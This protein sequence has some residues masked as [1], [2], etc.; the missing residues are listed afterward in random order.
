MFWKKFLI[1]PS[2][3]I[4]LFFMMTMQILID[5]LQIKVLGRELSPITVAYADTAPPS[6]DLNYPQ[7]NFKFA[8]SRVKGDENAVYLNI[9]SSQIG[10]KFVLPKEPSAT[11]LAKFDPSTN[12]GSLA[13]MRMRMVGP[14]L[15]AQILRITPTNFQS[16]LSPHF[17]NFAFLDWN[18]GSCDYA[19]KQLISTDPPHIDHAPIM[20]AFADYDYG[21][22]S[23]APFFALGSEQARVNKSNY[24]WDQRLNTDPCWTP[25]GLKDFDQNDGDWH[26]ISYNGFLNLVAFAQTVHKAALGF[27][28]ISSI[29]QDIQTTT[30]K[31]FFKKKVTE[32]VNYWLK[33]NWIVSTPARAGTYS[34]YAFNPSHGDNGTFSFVRVINNHSFPVQ[35]QL[36]YSWSKSWSGWTGLFVLVAIMVLAIVA[37]AVAGAALG[38]LGALGSSID[39][40]GGALIGAGVG[41]AV[42]GVGGLTAS[43]FSPSTA[44]TANFTPF[45]DSSYQLDPSQTAAGDALMVAN[46]TRSQWITPD[47]AATGGGV[48]TF[49]ENINIQN[50]LACGGASRTDSCSGVLTEIGPNDSRWSEAYKEMFF[51][52]HKELERYNYPYTNQ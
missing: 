46:N 15:T 41:G 8:L 42:G 11:I 32:T 21:R 17:Y 18:G 22:S 4:A 29:R 5:R 52:P 38:A 40:L 3:I 47:I 44:V 34:D 13:I 49:V 26:N 9:P 31:S 50:A 1:I 27:T 12:T 19:S 39:S 25:R 33:P 16:Y 37:C 51:F 45:S 28:A 6:T 23:I 48:Q 14:N 35:E 20:K 2:A 36:I 10:D 24:Y 30:S 7:G 43:G